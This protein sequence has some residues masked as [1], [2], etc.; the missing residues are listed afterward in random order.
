MET[1]LQGSH[2]RTYQAIF[3]HPVSRNLAWHDVCSMLDAMEGMVQLENEG[4]RKVSHNG[5]TVILHRPDRKNITDVGELM[6]L[7]RFLEQSQAPVPQASAAGAH[8]LVVIDHR[9]ARVYRAELHGSVPQRI[10]PYDRGGFGR[11]LHRVEEGADGKRKPEDNGFYQEVARTLEGAE[12]ILL[13]GAGTG[14]SSAMEQFFSELKK[15][16]KELAKRVVGL[17][18]VDEQHLS[19]DQLLAKAREVYASAAVRTGEVNG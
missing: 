17:H 9:L 10:I 12:M 8:L 19:E 15:H 4:T 1:S 16:H 18:V 11:H 13:F 6:K 2:H 14:A 3:Q 5:H 7:R